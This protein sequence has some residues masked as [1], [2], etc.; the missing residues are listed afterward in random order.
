MQI[1][2]RFQALALALLCGAALAPAPA[3]A[4]ESYMTLGLPFFEPYRV[5]IATI[6]VH[7]GKVSG[8]LAPPAGDPRAP[9]PLSG[10]L[11]NGRMTLVIGAGTNAYALDLREG[12][13]DIQQV[14]SETA[15]VADLDPVALFRP[16]GGFSE[17]GLA[18]QHLGANWCG[19]LIGGLAVELRTEALKSTAEPPA[20][21]ATLDVVLGPNRANRATAKL[22]DV[23]PR[24]R[25]AVLA[26]DATP[27][28][29][30][31]RAPLGGEAKLARALRALPQVTAVALPSSCG[32]MAL[33]SVPRE[34][35]MDGAEVSEAKLKAY[36]EQ[37]LP[38]LISGAEPGARGPGA[39]KFK[40]SGL[41]V[42]RDAAGLAF[43]GAT[44]QGDA[45]ATRLGKGEIDQF[46]LTLTPLVTAA[47]TGNT[48]SLLPSVSRLRTARR[49]GAQAPDEAA[50]KAVQDPAAVAAVDHRIASWIAAGEGTA[51]SFL[52]QTAFQEPE[53]ALV[54]SNR[55]LDS[56]RDEEDA[57]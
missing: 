13:Q 9:L 23:W 20:E 28:T 12:E 7:D 29:V 36:A 57:N 3:R 44:L 2:F 32:E 34:R 47:D 15:P 11:A 4:A 1:R 17:S 19:Q 14:W 54:C 38:R 56:V 27:V 43:V 18:L 31:V 33:V 21:L 52:T 30:D 39:R 41:Q 55:V 26:A 37:V 49:T 24:L 53:N 10:T 46:T 51:C 22:K 5:A 40:L 45:E 16:V 8:T 48:I 50:F 35:I 42:G 6:D 25:L